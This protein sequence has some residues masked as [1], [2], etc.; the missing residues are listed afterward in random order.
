MSKLSAIL[1]GLN[2]NRLNEGKAKLVMPFREAMGDYKDKEILDIV[3]ELDKYENKTHHIPSENDKVVMD[4]K[5]NKSYVYYI[6]KNI[7]GRT[8]QCIKVEAIIADKN[9]PYL[10]VYTVCPTYPGVRVK[11][12]GNF[13]KGS[14]PEE[15][16]SFI[17]EGKKNTSGGEVLDELTF[18]NIKV[19]YET[20]WHSFLQKRVLIYAGSQLLASLP[21]IDNDNEFKKYWKETKD[22]LDSLDTSGREAGYYK[23]Q[24]LHPKVKKELVNILNKHKSK[25]VTKKYDPVSGE[26]IK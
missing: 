7:K 12:D 19:I 18:G 11:P 26:I 15:I 14:T 17:S 3:D 6:N 23:Y 25:L 24:E 21:H 4:I 8:T 10:L 9:S 13:Y 1:E 16:E 5:G 20:Y 2:D 22:Y